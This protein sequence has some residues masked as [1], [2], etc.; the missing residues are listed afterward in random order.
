MSYFDIITGIIFIWAGIKGLKN[1]FVKELAGLTALILGIIMAVQFSD[2]TSDLISGFINTQYLG[3]IAF[4][5]T[6]VVVVVIVHLVASLIHMLLEAIALG[7]INRIIGLIFGV[8]KAGFIISVVLLGLNAFGLE[9]NIITSS[10]QERSKFYGPVKNVAPFFFELMN[11]DLN[12]ILKAE[13]EG[14]TF[15]T[16]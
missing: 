16:I 11:K 13:E 4:L 14:Q 6:F 8:L 12:D 2:V 15:L 1:G 9:D 5:I 10:E 7:L 3:I